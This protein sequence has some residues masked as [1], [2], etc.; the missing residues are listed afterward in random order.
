MNGQKSVQTLQDPMTRASVYRRN[1]TPYSRYE[2]GLTFMVRE[3][4]HF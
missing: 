3:F 2:C 1:H 4:S